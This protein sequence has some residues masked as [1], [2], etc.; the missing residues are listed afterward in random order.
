MV[1]NVSS[2]KLSSTFAHLERIEKVVGS[3]RNYVHGKHA[4]M[5]GEAEIR[6][7]LSKGVIKCKPEHYLRLLPCNG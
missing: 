6:T 1:V 7:L 4:Y 2:V 3:V 5:P